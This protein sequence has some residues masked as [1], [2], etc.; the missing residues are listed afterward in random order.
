MDR[1]QGTRIWM[2]SEAT[3][4]RCGFDRLGERVVQLT[5]VSNLSETTQIA[6]AVGSEASVQA[7]LLR[8]DCRAQELARSSA[9]ENAR[10]EKRTLPKSATSR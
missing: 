3:D 9:R 6:I 8:P 2:A 1:A 5:R 10:Q 4:M 7:R